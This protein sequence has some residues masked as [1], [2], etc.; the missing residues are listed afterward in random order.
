MSPQ[1]HT[2]EWRE[3]CR[4]ALAR[5]SSMA[6]REIRQR[7]GETCHIFRELWHLLPTSYGGYNTYWCVSPILCVPRGL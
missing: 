7:E 6:R 5:H 3:C 4:S 1:L 2:G